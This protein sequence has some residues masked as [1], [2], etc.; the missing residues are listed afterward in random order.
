MVFLYCIRPI[1]GGIMFSIFSDFPGMI[2]HDVLQTKD[3]SLTR[4]LL[5]MQSKI[6]QVTYTHLI[7][8]HV[9]TFGFLTLFRSHHLPI[10]T[11]HSADQIMTLDSMAVCVKLFIDFLF[12]TLSALGSLTVRGTRNVSKAASDC[13][14]QERA[15]SATPVFSLSN[16]GRSFL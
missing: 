4:W 5:Y 10:P 15:R 1:N 9:E 11:T 2:C 6:K 13:L 7:G 3:I 12:I 16:V 14:T 8:R